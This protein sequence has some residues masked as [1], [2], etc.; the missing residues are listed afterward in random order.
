MPSGANRPLR[1]QNIRPKALVTALVL[2]HGLSVQTLVFAEDAQITAQSIL[3][4]RIQKIELDSEASTIQFR[5][6]KKACATV[7]LVSRCTSEALV[8]RRSR[9]AVLRDGQVSAKEQLRAMAAKA[10]NNDLANAQARTAESSRDEIQR[11]A[12]LAQQAKKLA[13]AQ[14]RLDAHQQKKSQEEDNR[15]LYR[16][17]VQRSEEKQAEIRA[18]FK[19]SGIHPKAG[20]SSVVTPPMALNPAGK[21]ASTANAN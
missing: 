15:R 9:D 18:R 19:D 2:L 20:G 8:R 12:G 21:S 13:D 6:D 5:A 10:K 3:Q 14:E 11:E 1:F 16:E 7:I 17:K 4:A